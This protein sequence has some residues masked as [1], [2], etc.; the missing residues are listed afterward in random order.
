M[1]VVKRYV[2]SR[3]G[4][5]DGLIPRPEKSYRLWCVYVCDQINNNPLHLPWLGRKEVGLRKKDII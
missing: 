4:L 1:F 2:L 5:C 3:T